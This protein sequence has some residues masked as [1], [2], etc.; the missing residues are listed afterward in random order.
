MGSMRMK[1]NPSRLFRNIIVRIVIVSSATVPLGAL[2]VVALL[3]LNHVQK[4]GLLIVLPCLSCLLLAVNFA[5]HKLYLKPLFAAL[6]KIQSGASITEKEQLAAE[7]RA[8]IYPHFSII[9]SFILFSCGGS[10]LALIL[11]KWT[12]LK[13]DGAIYILSSA[14]TTSFIA[15]IACFYVLRPPI[16]KALALIMKRSGSKFEKP[17]FFVPIAVN[18]TVSFVLIITLIPVFLGLLSY[19]LLKRTTLAAD[20]LFHLKQ[21]SKIGKYVDD[22]YRNSNDVSGLLIAL[23]DPQEFY[24]LA[25]TQFNPINCNNTPPSPEIAEALKSLP[26]GSTIEDVSNSLVWSWVPAQNNQARL[27]AAWAPQRAET[28]RTQVKHYYLA[29]AIIMIFVGAALGILSAASISEPLRKFST[30]AVAISEGKRDIE[31]P[32]GAEDETGVLARAFSKMTTVLLSQLHDEI[33]NGRSL[34]KS[35]NEAVQT[36]A[37]M[38]GELVAIA[39]Q[40]ASGSVQQAGAAE[41]A[42]TTSQEIASVS[43]QIAQ[44][45]AEVASAAAGASQVTESGKSIL[46]QTKTEF[47]DVQLKMKNIADA[48]LRLGDQSQEIGQILLIIEE[49]G[50]QTNLLAL[51]A[52][53]EA[54]GAGESGRRFGVVAQEIRR[55]SQ[56]TANST[57]QINEIVSRM[58]KSVSSSI[59]HAEEGDKAVTAGMKMLNKMNKLFGNIF[60]AT[61]GAVPRLKEIDLMTAQQATASEQMSKTIDEV[62]ETSHQAANFAQELKS[63]VEE[64]DKIVTILKNNLD[65]SSSERF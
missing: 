21:L 58:Q 60:E 7:R 62:K 55:L 8:L 65:K 4:M 13:T 26:E 43:R 57:K 31:I 44:H 3:S 38:A 45:A 37:P 1:D 39:N 25:D 52:S 11:M 48:V 34:M 50:E 20:N 22:S 10:L 24:C 19:T 64:L 35:I 49:I 56:T 17:P 40:Q 51:N 32:S 63:S 18:L 16:Q 41:Q 29:A 23:N 28:L 53:I 15:G 36:L 27:I 46:N 42:A 5:I 12:G 14:I 2:Y 54:V 61:K 33:E 6:E 59:M 9:M 30:I 47:D